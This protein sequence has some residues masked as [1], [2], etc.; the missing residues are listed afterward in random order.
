MSI[1]QKTRNQ[2]CTRTWLGTWKPANAYN[3]INRL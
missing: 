2:L 1:N 3:M